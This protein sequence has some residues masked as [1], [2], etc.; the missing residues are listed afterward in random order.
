MAP[1]EEHIV[2]PTVREVW[3]I[4]K[5][6]VSTTLRLILLRWV[7]CGSLIITGLLF[8]ALPVIESQVKGDGVFL[9]PAL[10]PALFIT[11]HHLGT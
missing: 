1:N 2:F 10:L 5:F 3:W 8:A 11:L 6:M 4:P 7:V 9:L